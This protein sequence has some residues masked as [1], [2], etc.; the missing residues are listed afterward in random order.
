MCRNGVRGTGQFHLISAFGHYAVAC[1]HAREYLHALAVVGSQG[2]ELF[3]V[4]LLVQLQVDEE[5]AL[6]FGEC[7]TGQGDDVLHRRGKQVDLH[8]GAGHD[9]PLVVELEGDGH[10]ISASAARC[11]AVGEEAAVQFA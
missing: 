10:V 11:L 5:A 9:V 2:D 4:A 8:E 7:R 3:L 6:L 1:L